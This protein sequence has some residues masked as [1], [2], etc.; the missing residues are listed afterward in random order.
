MWSIDEDKKEVYMHIVSF[1]QNSVG[2]TP[3]LDY[4]F[5]Y[6]G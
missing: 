2:R 3:S 5:Q 4:Q 1:E 6:Y